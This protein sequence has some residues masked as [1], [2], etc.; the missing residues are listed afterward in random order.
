PPTTAPLPAG[1]LSANEMRT[2]AQASFNAYPWRSNQMALLKGSNYSITG[3]TEV[4]GPGLIHALQQTKQGDVVS[5][6]EIVL[7]TPT[8]F[9]KATNA[10][11]QELQRA[12]LTN[13]Q[14]AKLTAGNT[15]TST[16]YSA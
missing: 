14:W 10:P 3:V 4:A 5:T 12:G 11:P 2:L 16:L 1:D 8:L 15:Y 9:I 13:G 6:I 7:I